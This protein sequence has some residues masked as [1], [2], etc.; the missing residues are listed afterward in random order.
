MAEYTELY[1]SW[2][3]SISRFFYFS[4]FFKILQYWILLSIPVSICIFRYEKF[5][6]FFFISFDFM[7]FSISP[8]FFIFRI[9]ILCT[10]KFK[11]EINHQKMHAMVLIDISSGSVNWMRSKWEWF[12]CKNKLFIIIRYRRN[13]FYRIRNVPLILLHFSSLNR[14]TH[15]RLM[16]LMI[17]LLSCQM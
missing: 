11:M 8:R 17:L 9:K 1:A 2:L 13:T 6:K 12:V 5:L 3:N 10:L 15:Y 4:L 7:E 14:H 16:I